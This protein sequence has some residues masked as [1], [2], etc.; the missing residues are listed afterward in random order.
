MFLKTFFVYQTDKNEHVQQTPPQFFTH[1]KKLEIH[2]LIKWL[3]GG[4]KSDD[5]PLFLKENAKNIKFEEGLLENN[6]ILDVGLYDGEESIHA[7]KVGFTVIGI[8]ANPKH[9]PKIFQNLKENS[10]QDKLIFINCT[11]QN[12]LQKYY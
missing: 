4:F 6:I 3:N 10:I 2:P 9:I 1:S 11:N 5:I 8:E 7:L 12:D